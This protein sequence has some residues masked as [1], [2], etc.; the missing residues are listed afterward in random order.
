M[1]TRERVEAV[2]R[3]GARAHRADVHVR[4]RSGRVHV[5][6]VFAKSRESGSPGEVRA[7]IDALVK[8]IERIQGKS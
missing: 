5:A 7:R 2:R 6:S 3:A 4:N 1:I 8:Y